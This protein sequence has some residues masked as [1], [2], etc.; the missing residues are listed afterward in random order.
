MNKTKNALLILATIV[1]SL[2][3]ASDEVRRYIDEGDTA[4]IEGLFEE[5]WNPNAPID[6]VTGYMPLVFAASHNKQGIVAVLLSGGADPNVASIGIFRGNTALMWASHSGNVDM[7]ESL[8]A[9]GARIN[10]RNGEDGTALMWAAKA[11]KDEAVDV[12]L[13][14]GADPFFTATIGCTAAML[15]KMNGHHDIVERLEEAP[16]LVEACPRAPLRGG[17]Y[18]AYP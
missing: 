16:D 14:R 7:L 5:G 9:S 18:W 8:L 13:H 17:G 4:A 15:A 1:A 6:T 12:L 2:G 3:W 10:T 11:G